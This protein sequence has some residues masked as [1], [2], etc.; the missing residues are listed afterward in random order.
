MKQAVKS[1]WL[2]RPSLASPSSAITAAL[3]GIFLRASGFS[4]WVLIGYVVHLLLASTVPSG[5]WL[6][7]P[8]LGSAGMRMV[9]R[10][11]LRFELSLM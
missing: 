3:G 4:D 9:L 2:M 1:A 10:L 7:R 8:G 11:P 6:R 5:V